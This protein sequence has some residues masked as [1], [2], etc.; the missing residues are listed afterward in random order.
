MLIDGLDFVEPMHVV[1]ISMY[2]CVC[3]CLYVNDWY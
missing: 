3:V 2:V 1:M